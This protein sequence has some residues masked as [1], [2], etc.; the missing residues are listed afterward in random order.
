M[1]NLEDKASFFCAPS[2]AAAA[3]TATTGRYFLCSVW[4][5]M[6]L[7]FPNLA[8]AW[9]LK[10]QW[11]HRRVRVTGI[12]PYDARSHLVHSRQQSRALLIPVRKKINKVFI[13][14]LCL[15]WAHFRMSQQSHFQ[16]VETVF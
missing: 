13:F 14:I 9:P 7:V 16:K 11:V 2:G 4:S 3:Y 10:R 15:L 5:V 8:L 1:N 6:D 12:S